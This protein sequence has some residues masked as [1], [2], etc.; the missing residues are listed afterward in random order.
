MFCWELG[1][2]DD[3]PE[4]TGLLCLSR[5]HNGLAIG[6]PPDVDTGLAHYYGRSPGQ[7]PSLAGVGRPALVRRDLRKPRP[8]RLSKY[9]AAITAIELHRKEIAIA[10]L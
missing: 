3:G 5:D 10:A 4:R 6:G 9:L 2:C 1:F 8:G 7:R